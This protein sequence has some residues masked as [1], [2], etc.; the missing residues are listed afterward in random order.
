MTARRTRSSGAPT[1]SSRRSSRPTTARPRARCRGSRLNSPTGRRRWRSSGCS[2]SP[3]RPKK[4]ARGAAAA[5]G[6]ARAAASA[7]ARRRGP[8]PARATAAAP[9]HRRRGPA[10]ETVRAR[11]V[12]AVGRRRGR[13]HVRGA[14]AAHR[15][16]VRRRPARGRRAASGP[17]AA[18]GAASIAP[19]DHRRHAAA[20]RRRDGATAAARRCTGGQGAEVVVCFLVID[21]RYLMYQGAR[22]FCSGS[23]RYTKKSQIELAYID[24]L[25][26]PKI[27]LD[28]VKRTTQI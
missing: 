2:A 5:T 8:V 10:P 20:V 27:R 24:T 12:E 7:T 16:P 13:G 4:S 22:L 11:G 17:R 1:G 3:R 14:E 25:A 21:L 23:P 9:G 26:N 18:T 6:A 15:R 19:R 28:G